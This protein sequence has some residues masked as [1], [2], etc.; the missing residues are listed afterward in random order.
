M[1][2]Q[3]NGLLTCAVLPPQITQRIFYISSCDINQAN[4]LSCVVLSALLADLA[5]SPTD[6]TNVK[7][8]A[9]RSR[10]GQMGVS[11]MISASQIQN[12]STR[13]KITT[14]VCLVN[15]TG[16]LHLWQE[17]ERYGRRGPGPYV[18][19]TIGASSHLVDC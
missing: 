12:V 14:K 9:L 7:V 1:Y 18:Y 3:V 2:M 16:Q 17:A 5:G 6:P 8:S 15:T 13:L 10:F 11:A 4:S 19:I